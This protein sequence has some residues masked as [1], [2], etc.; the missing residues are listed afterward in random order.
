LPAN[1][2][3]YPRSTTALRSSIS[4]ALCPQFVV[5]E[6]L[7]TTVRQSRPQLAP[8]HEGFSSLLR[9]LR[10]HGSQVRRFGNVSASTRFPT[11]GP[12]QDCGGD[13]L[14]SKNPHLENSVKRKLSRTRRVASPSLRATAHQT[15]NQAPPKQRDHQPPYTNPT[16]FQKTTQTP[17]TPGDHAPP[18]AKSTRSA[19]RYIICSN[20]AVYLAWRV[21]ISQQFCVWEEGCRDLTK[22]EHNRCGPLQWMIENAT[23]SQDNILAHRYWTLVTAAFSQAG[24]EHLLSNMLGLAVLAPT[25]CKAG[26]VGIGAAHVVGLTIGSALVSD[27]VSIMYR[28]K[29]P[30]QL[31]CAD[32]EKSRREQCEGGAGASGIQCAFITGAACIRPTSRFTVGL[33]RLPSWMACLGT[34]SFV[35]NCMFFGQDDKIAHEV[36]LAGALFGIV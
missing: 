27:L 24:F 35:A 3:L 1:H 30:T 4:T 6:Y 16:I 20:V 33:F 23:N 34:C 31:S 13:L 2:T 8:K 18:Y 19:V 21:S 17:S 11:C 26:G 28:W 5:D 22:C 14:L 9:P 32:P 7:A 25:F 12:L 15:P 36:H 10:R 29:S